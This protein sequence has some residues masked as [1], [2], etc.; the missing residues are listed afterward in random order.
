[1]NTW[2][3]DMKMTAECEGKQTLTHERKS[4][5]WENGVIFGSTQT[6]VLCP[7]H[8]ISLP[9]HVK[10]QKPQL[11]VIELHVK[12]HVKILCGPLQWETNNIGFGGSTGLP[13]GPW[14][15]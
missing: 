15:S 9:H 1:M 10:H 7:A 2:D 11:H 6:G 14:K 3:R 12:H 8:F 4:T 5:G 13:T